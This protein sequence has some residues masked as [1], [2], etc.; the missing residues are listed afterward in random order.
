MEE[1]QKKVDQDWKEKVEKEKAAPKDKDAF[2]PPPPDFKFFVTTLAMQASIALG[3]MPNPATDKVEEDLV[4]AKFLIDTLGMLQEKTN[5]NLSKEETEL[6]E[7]LLYELRVAY[8]EKE[9]G[10]AK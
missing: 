7:N 6:L 2:V 8:L 9:K 5:N 4:Q 3:H 10:K 1:N